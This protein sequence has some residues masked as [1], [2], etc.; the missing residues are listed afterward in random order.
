MKNVSNRQCVNDYVVAF[1]NIWRYVKFGAEFVGVFIS[2]SDRKSVK[3]NS[4]YE[5]LNK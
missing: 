2:E 5:Q 3:R 4:K 1:S